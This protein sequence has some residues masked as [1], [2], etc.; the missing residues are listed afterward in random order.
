MRLSPWLV[1]FC[2][3]AAAGL[4]FAGVSTHD[5]VQHLD[6]QVH[7]I[8][9][10]FIPGLAAPDASGTSGCHVTLMSPYSSLFRKSV[11]GGLPISLPAM[12]VFAFLLYRGL[13][14]LVNRRADD[15]GAR[16]FLVG[17]S[18][19]PVL[20]SL[21]MGYIAFAELDA[22]C[23]LCIGIYAA[24]F[25]SLAAAAIEWKTA[26][27]S[28]PNL[29]SD[30]G[31]GGHEA[32]FAEQG[33]DARA[34][35]LGAATLAGFVA[36]PTLVYLIAMPTYDKYVGSCGT[37]AKPE[38]TYKIMVPMDGNEAGRDTIEVFDPLC[39]ACRGFEDRLS[40]SGLSDQLHRRAVLFPLD[41]T[42]N[43]MVGSAV[44]P[45]A[46][47]ISEAILCA[48]ADAKK[49]VDWAFDNQQAIRAASAADPAAAG[50]MVAAAFP[51]LKSC[52]GSTKVKADLN[53]SLR[54]VVA[55]QLPV[56]TPQVYVGGTKLCDE[57]T[58]LGM[59]YALSRLLEQG[60]QKTASA[61]TP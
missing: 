31:L 50:N 36:V 30:I 48:D 29:G 27:G 14:L 4:M 3:A 54:W 7:S 23:K 58:D 12:S 13:D 49:V 34:W 1:L 21:V 11:W 28:D 6:R 20:A 22:A 41:N 57:D 39:P 19:L 16:R 37:L 47:T 8:N 55:N 44:H 15:A 2:V 56:L 10:S 46:C 61:E 43:W 52:L 32:E 60:P 33:G 35:A 38:D 25:V 9:C 51:Q 42:C 40:A 53:R 5:F 26:A 17:A 18:V 45:G 24:S 59:D